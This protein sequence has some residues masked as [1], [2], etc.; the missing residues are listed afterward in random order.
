MVGQLTE[1]VQSEIASV[2]RPQPA[3]RRAARAGG[4][5]DAGRQ[6]PVDPALRAVPAGVRARR[7]RLPV[8]AGRRPVRRLPR[9]VHRR[10]LRPLPAGDP[11]RAA[12]GAGPR[13]QLR[14]RQR[15]RAA[16]GRAD[17][18]P[19]PERRPGAVHQLRHRGQPD[20]ARAGRG[21]DRAPEDPGLPGR[22]PRRR[23]HL[24]RDAEP[25]HGAARVGAGGLRRRRRHPVADPRARSRP[26][27]RTR[28]ADAGCR[29][30]RPGR[31]RSSSRCCAPRPRRP[32]RCSSS[33]R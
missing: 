5:V 3:Q 30:L 2:R 8:V 20:G 32:A 25:G 12:H 7:G 28:R 6:H 17:L 9:R 21:R 16:A 22:L 31:A 10:A 15:A 1:A 14:R 4:E 33:T 23:A 29:R 26:G 13:A 11:R 24:R 19:V 27:R 18:R